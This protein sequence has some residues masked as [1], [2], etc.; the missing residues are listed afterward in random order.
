MKY[1]PIIIMLLL[2]AYV[3]AGNEDANEAQR[4]QDR[5]CNM[6]SQ[7]AWP[8]YRENFDEVCK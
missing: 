4:Q 7:G 1:A 2:G 5:Y 8:D 6:V 3:W